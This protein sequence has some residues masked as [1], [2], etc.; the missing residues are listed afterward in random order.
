M[1]SPFPPSPKVWRK[2]FFF[3]V[4]HVMW[5]ESCIYIFWTLVR[6]IFVIHFSNIINIVILIQNGNDSSRYL[7]II[8]Y[9]SHTMLSKTMHL[10]KTMAW[11]WDNESLDQDLQ[12]LEKGE[13]ELE[14][15]STHTSTSNLFLWPEAR[16]S[17]PVHTPCMD[18]S[19]RHCQALGSENSERHRMGQTLATCAIKQKTKK[20]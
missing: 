14:C 7:S 12:N 11:D 19:W 10:S 2:H 9:D 16:R 5:F 18:T 3:Y 6:Y 4:V 8:A 1:S 20:H 13:D 15:P 17:C